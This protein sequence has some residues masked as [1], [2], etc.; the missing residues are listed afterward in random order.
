ML[1]RWGAVMLLV[2]KL[3]IIHCDIVMTHAL[4][5]P[6][7]PPSSRPRLHQ[8]TNATLGLLMLLLPA[9]R[10]AL[11]LLVL[12]PPPRAAPSAASAVSGGGAPAPAAPAASASS[13]WNVTP[14][15]SGSWSA[16]PTGAGISLLSLWTCVWWGI[17]AN[18]DINRV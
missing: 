14:S 18:D 11:P 6:P 4:Q 8:P 9:P 16:V 12:L 5:L 13:A 1:A 2:P 3:T 10:S 15:N 7:P 17:T